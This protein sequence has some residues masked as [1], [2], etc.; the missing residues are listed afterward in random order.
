R[1]LSIHFFGESITEPGIEHTNLYLYSQ[2]DYPEHFSWTIGASVDLF[3]DDETVDRDQFNPKFG[4]T[5]TPYK[6]TT[7]R[8]TVFRTLKRSLASRQT[9][10][11]SQ[12][13]GFNQFFDD[14]NGTRSWRYGVALDQAFS[15][16]IHGG[17]EFSRRDSDVPQIDLI[18][19]DIVDAD[20][21]EHVARG[22]VYWTPHPF[23]SLSAEYLFERFE[24][25]DNFT[26]EEQ[27]RNLDTHRF[28]LGV[29]FFHPNGLSAHVRLSYI[30]QQGTFGT[31]ITDLH[32]DGDRFW[33]L[34]AS[35]RY[36]L[37]KRF[38]FVTLSARNL[39]DNDFDFQD[40]DL[41]NKAIFP[42]RV[43]LGKLTFS[44]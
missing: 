23:W 42:E 19:G 26:G 9:I 28:P 38:G 21:K 10:E 33:L 3:K 29:S 20:W 22:Y 41:A 11:P 34:D 7:L 13:A 27:V 4:L 24:R 40:M 5:L 44:F 30:D 2:I 6:G 14:T 17:A 25:Q 43:I 18:S 37:P 36:R 39:L 15:A 12:V 31:D 32:S 35:L 1:D 16:D 8:A